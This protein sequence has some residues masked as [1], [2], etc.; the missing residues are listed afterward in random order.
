MVR[1]G[2]NAGRP[3][4]LGRSS[5]NGLERSGADRKAVADQFFEAQRLCRQ[6]A[7]DRCIDL[8]EFIQHSE[9]F[10]NLTHTNAIGS[11]ALGDIVARRL[12]SP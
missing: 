9:N 10:I 8:S 4:P 1:H 7:G 5:S 12:T 3:Q 11:K 6:L 2:G